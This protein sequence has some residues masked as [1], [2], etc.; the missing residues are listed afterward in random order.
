MVTQDGYEQY[1]QALD[2]SSVLSKLPKIGFVVNHFEDANYVAFE[3]LGDSMDDGTIN[4]IPNKAIV[5]G[6]KIQIKEAFEENNGISDNARIIVCQDR[7]LFKQIVGFVKES[8]TIVCHNFN[9][10]P[11]YKDFE[12]PIDDVLQVF[13]IIRKQL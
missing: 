13:E 5:F 7:V 10:S 1:I 8:N 6:K 9:N 3:V 11:E 12:L 4:A 2:A